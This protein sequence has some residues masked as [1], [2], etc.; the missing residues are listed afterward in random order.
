MFKKVRILTSLLGI[1]S[2]TSIISSGFCV[3]YFDESGEIS[4]TLNG[5]EVDVTYVLPSCGH[6][7][8]YQDESSDHDHDHRLFLVFEEG[9]DPSDLKSGLSFYQFSDP[10]VNGSQELI[11]DSTLRV[12]FHENPELDLVEHPE[13]EFKCEITIYNG[14]SSDDPTNGTFTLSHFLK[15]SDN[16]NGEFFLKT[17]TSTITNC[18]DHTSSNI[19]QYAMNLNLND[20]FEYTSQDVKPTNIETFE[21]LYKSIQNGLTKGWNIEIIFSVDYKI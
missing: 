7:L 6:F 10:K 5:V 14:T 13:L 4:L 3:W 17:T 20:C 21:I 11:N 18:K 19:T 12:Y 15:V 8:R 2:L 1:L 16:Y 9:E